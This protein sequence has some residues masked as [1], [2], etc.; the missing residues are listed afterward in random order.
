MGKRGQ[1]TNTELLFVI[2]AFILAAVVGLDLLNDTRSSLEG[3]LL[4]KNY[5]ARD[6]ALTIDA[7]YAS[8]ADISYTYS[9][10]DLSLVKKELTIAV[11]K[12]EQGILVTVKDNTKPVSYKVVGSDNVNPPN[13]DEM[14]D[15]FKELK[16]SKIFNADGS[17]DILIEAGYHG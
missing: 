10:R 16:L 1:H 11:K 12:E 4:E 5:L 3:T 6:L 8:P 14:A 13:F 2:T 9:F 7:I 17:A 15:N